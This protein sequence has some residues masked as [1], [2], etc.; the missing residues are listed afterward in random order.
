MKIMKYILGPELYWMLVFIISVLLSKSNG[1]PTYAYDHII[2]ASWL[3]IPILALLSFCLFYMPEVGKNGLLIRTWLSGIIAG[4][5]ILLAL[6]IAYSQQG[7]G[8]GMTYLAGMIFL[9]VALVIG[10]M[11]VSLLKKS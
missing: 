5:F 3:I 6:S 11:F 7:P 10:S 4:H 2:E 9:F 8:S 1:G